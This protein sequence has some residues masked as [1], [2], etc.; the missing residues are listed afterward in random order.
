M[1]GDLNPASPY[2]AYAR[3]RQ[4]PP[5][6]WDADFCGGAWLVHRHQDVQKALRNPDLSV[7]RI[8]GWVSQ[9]GAEPSPRLQAFK[10]LMARTLVFIDRPRHTRVRRV[11]NA[12]FTPKALE[13]LHG[14][15]EKRVAQAFLTLEQKLQSGQA[16]LVEQICRPLPAQVMMDLLGVELLP[17]PLFQV[18]SEQLACFIGQPTPDTTLLADTQDAL[19]EMANFLSTPSNLH[20]NGLAWRLLQDPHLSLKGRQERLAQS[21]MLL[22]A[23]YETSRH[24]LST[25]FQ[26]L[27]SREDKRQELERNPEQIPAA[28]KEVLRHDSPIQYTA[29]RVM[30]DQHWHGQPLRK[31]Q[32]LLLL[33]GAANRDPQV[34]SHADELNFSRSPQTELSMGHGIHHCLGAGLVHLEAKLSLQKFLPLLARL[35]L[36]GGQRVTLPAYR[37]WSSLPVKWRA[38]PS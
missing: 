16:D 19:L 21:C 9:A 26:T 11:L 7:R 23:G 4:G 38:I 34:F 35:Q 31:G 33:L 10:G 12:A 30:R 14:T 28:I 25:L 6:V 22:F 5:L 32:L 18:W 29:R 13:S 1:F 24:L 37:G 8:G 15:I 27:L 3:L 36:Q 20:E 17:L 2:P